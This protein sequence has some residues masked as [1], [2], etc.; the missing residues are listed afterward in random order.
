[1]NK[2]SLC[3]LRLMLFTTLLEGTNCSSQLPSSSGTI[4]PIPVKKIK[5][6]KK[7][8]SE[9]SAMKKGVEKCLKDFNS[10]LEEY[11]KVQKEG[12]GLLKNKDLL[13]SAEKECKNKK[14]IQRFIE[15]SEKIDKKNAKYMEEYEKNER[16]L[17]DLDNATIDAAS[18]E[19]NPNPLEKFDQ[20]KKLIISLNKSAQQL[21]ELKKKLTNNNINNTPAVVTPLVEESPKTLEEKIEDLKPVVKQATEMVEELK[22]EI[23]KTNAKDNREE[24]EKKLKEV[25]VKQDQLGKLLEE[26]LI[27]EIDGKRQE[28]TNEKFKKFEEQMPPI[29]IGIEEVQNYLRNAKKK[30]SSQ[31]K[32]EKSITNIPQLEVANKSV[33]AKNTASIIGGGAIVLG[34]AT[35]AVASVSSNESNDNNHGE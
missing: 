6:D 24:I 35:A 11:K 1:M 21:D 10:L 23:K 17:L 4:P 5:L 31:S 14:K 30:P 25:I 8:A 22:K 32:E 33:E 20:Q 18:K 16:L 7:E 3:S 9:L 13:V 29:N 34:V 19:K 27:V 28:N 12:E 26:N 2:F 15:E